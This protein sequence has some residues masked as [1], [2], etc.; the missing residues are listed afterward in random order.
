MSKDQ[1]TKIIAPQASQK[2]DGEKK[3]RNYAPWLVA[4]IGVYFSLML[5][6][7]FLPLSGYMK[8]LSLLLGAFLVFDIHHSI[9]YYVKTR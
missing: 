3:Q 9:K 6:V 2:T 5:L 8:V 7:S 1:K 4:L